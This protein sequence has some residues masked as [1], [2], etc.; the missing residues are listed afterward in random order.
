MKIEALNSIFR[1]NKVRHAV[2]LLFFL[3]LSLTAFEPGSAQLKNQRRVTGVQLSTAAEGSRVIVAS[4]TPLN[5]YEGFRRGDRFYVKI[6]WAD[7]VSATPRFRADG[8]DDVQVQKVG[9]SVV[10]SF[11]LQPGASA[12]IDQRGNRLEV[13][14]SVAKKAFNAP[15]T[16][17]ANRNSPGNLSPYTSVS[18]ANNDFAGPVPP[19]SAST[20]ERFVESFD[21]SSFSRNSRSPRFN[22]RAS[23]GGNNAAA[24]QALASASPLPSPA[25]TFSPVRST[26]YPPLTIASPT[27]LNNSNS[28]TTAARTNSSSW[29][30]RKAAITRWVS[31]NR[32]ATALGALI[33][34]SLLAYL[35]SGWRQRK[36]AGAGGGQ[37][38]SSKVQPKYSESEVLD[39]L[40]PRDPLPQRQSS[41]TNQ[42]AAVTTSQAESSRRLTRP[43]IVP[44]GGA[45]REISDKEDREVFEL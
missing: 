6:P 14:F 32:L 33:L 44:A 40:T 13:V 25:A 42:E 27:N 37:S 35:I 4:D 34:L 9:D 36:A 11:K 23:S 43:N 24:T 10:I 29:S 18:S 22:R 31:A 2:A 15:L 1:I 21:Q 12:R 26:G 39:E 5:D 17:D 7:F 20:R 45:G 30:D 8:F 38:K 16:A 41:V 19:T 3:G 28:A